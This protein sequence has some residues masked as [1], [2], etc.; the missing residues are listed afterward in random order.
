MKEFDLELA[1]QGKPV[2]TRDGIKA[3]IVCYDRKDDNY[4]IVA[5]VDYDGE[6]SL[7]SYSKDGKI[8][9]R[10]KTPLGANLMMASEKHEGWVNIYRDVNSAAF[11]GNIIY[12]S[13][14]DAK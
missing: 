9:C 5:L 8:I 11:T 6:E 4:P 13:E 14:D 12:D 1:K 2:C 10:D 3:R 7:Y